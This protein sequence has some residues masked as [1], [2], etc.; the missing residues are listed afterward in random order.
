M[1]M[2]R[3]IKASQ[4]PFD[5]G[6]D[7]QGRVMVSFNILAVKALSFTFS[8]EIVSILVD[9]AIGVFGEDLFASSKTAL[10]IEGTIIVVIE[11][12]GMGPE[13]VQNVPLGPK[14]QQP[15]AM[16]HVHSED[17]ETA[18]AKA[19]AA[20]YALVTVK[21]QDIAPYGA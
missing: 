5:M 10:P 7:G 2:Y 16:I 11:T 9:A 14:Y 8:R 15:G 4:E 1:T 21:N 13:M 20:Y 18:M 3:S 17:Y 12:G 6:Q 19:S